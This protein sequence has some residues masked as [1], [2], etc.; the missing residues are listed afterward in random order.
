M[1]IFIVSFGSEYT[2]LQAPPSPKKPSEVSRL[3]VTV[4]LQKRL[5]EVADVIC[6]QNKL[7]KLPAEVTVDKILEKFV[8]EIQ[9][10][11]VFQAQTGTVEEVAAGIKQYFNSTLGTQ[12]LYKQERQQFKELSDVTPSEYYGADH[13]LRLFVRFGPLLS[14]LSSEEDSQVILLSHLQLCLQLVA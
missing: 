12:L 14:Q 11:D 7:L 10:K 2:I 1:L 8:E 5:L 6:K 4:V 9:Q 3:N 13:L